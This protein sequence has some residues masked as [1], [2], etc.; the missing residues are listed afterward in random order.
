MWLRLI[1][2]VIFMPKYIKIIFF[3]FLKII[4]KISTSKWSKKYKK[5]LIKKII[6]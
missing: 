4:F 3:N 6:F 2:K 5:I 1:F